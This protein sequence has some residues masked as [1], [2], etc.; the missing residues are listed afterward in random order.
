[1]ASCLILCAPQ[2]KESHPAAT[3]W[4]NGIKN[5]FA[6]LGGL[7]RLVDWTDGSIAL[8]DAEMEQFARLVPDGTPIELRP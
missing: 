4:C 3:L 2:A 8:A 6:W 7:Y 5:G 1:M